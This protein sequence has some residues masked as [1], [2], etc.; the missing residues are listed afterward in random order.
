[1]ASDADGDEPLLSIA[2]VAELIGASKLDVYRL[3]DSGDLPARRVGAGFRVPA[4][5]ARAYLDARGR[6]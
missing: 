4:S 3:V 5:A 1:M 2:E 6:G